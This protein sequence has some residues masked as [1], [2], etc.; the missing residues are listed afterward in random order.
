[1]SKKIKKFSI[2]VYIFHDFLK[3]KVSHFLKKIQFYTSTAKF[4][5]RIRFFGN[6]P[7]LVGTLQGVENCETIQKL[8]LV[9]CGIGCI[10]F[11]LKP[12]F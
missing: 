3:K 11:F 2:F 10:I 9:A 6:F 4:Y 12:G 8:H 1:M 5:K 7:H